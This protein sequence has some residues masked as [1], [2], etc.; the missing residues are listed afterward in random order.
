V[1]NA[2]VATPN[3]LL[4]LAR[5]GNNWSQLEV[6]DRI[7]VTPNTYSRWERGIIIPTPRNQERLSEVYRK[8]P[9]ELGFFK[10]ARVKKSPEVQ[11][12]ST[13][14]Y[15]DLEKMLTRII[16]R[17]NEIE[18]IFNYL[19]RDQE[20][21]VT[22]TGTG[23]VGKTHLALAVAKRL[24]VDSHY[25]TIFVSLASLP[26]SS[27]ILPTIGVQLGLN[28]PITPER[29]KAT[30][31][32]LQA[33][34]VV[35]ILDNFEHVRTKDNISLLTYLLTGCTDKLQLIVTSRNLLRVGYGQVVR[36]RPLQVPKLKDIKV[37]DD[38]KK[39][40]ATALYLQR[41]QKIKDDFDPTENDLPFIVKV[42]ERLNGLP[43]A[44]V[45]VI[46]L[47]RTYSPE[48]QYQTLLRDVLGF[49]NT[50]YTNVPKRQISL[51]KTIE[52]SYNQLSEKEKK[53]FRRLAIFTGKC[54]VESA[55][56]ICNLEED[57]SLE[58]H[59]FTT[60]V[61]TLNDWFLISSEDELIEIAH[62]II[63]DFALRKLKEE[64]KGDKIKNQFISYYFTLVTDF[65]VTKES[66]P[67]LSEDMVEFCHNLRGELDNLRE[68]NHE[69]DI[70]MIEYAIIVCA[71][72]YPKFNHV[73][74]Y[75]DYL[76]LEQ[77]A[78]KAIKVVRAMPDFVENMLYY[79]YIKK[80]ND[81]FD[82]SGYEMFLDYLLIHDEW[83]T[84][85]KRGDNYDEFVDFLKANDYFDI[86]TFRREI[87]H[88]FDE[89]VLKRYT[90]SPFPLYNV[91]TWF[92]AIM[93]N[94][95]MEEKYGT[96]H[97]E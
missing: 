51:Y 30:I 19:R 82:S 72:K 94:M 56:Y 87:Q 5:E 73:H 27:Y 6:A 4:I 96:S 79:D 52:W 64:G 16:G 3:E 14:P 31:R 95:E 29:V 33:E 34:R 24:E 86:T 76:E 23:G 62:N 28:E 46:P 26:N 90:D 57:L 15:E 8:K 22:I 9:E 53:L 10:Q 92:M 17:E 7:G 38:L 93:A 68:V 50:F 36:L 48:M 83:G 89:A 61:D 78:I 39:Y 74:S 35:I 54:R 12:I 11:L 42:C 55:I 71:S 59:D 84:N 80:A 58:K 67:G 20:G 2:S 40:S 63:R 81:I 66:V 77:K 44:I 32:E 65:M 1:R 97:V 43:L 75:Q 37:V 60:I 13:M 69:I 41:A 47:L 21:L 18:I 25:K 85:R 45:L 70:L 91:Y 49:E 88:V